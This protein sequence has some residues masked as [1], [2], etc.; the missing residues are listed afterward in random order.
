[1]CTKI[2]IFFSV[3]VIVF[4]NRYPSLI[5]FGFVSHFYHPTISQIFEAALLLVY[6]ILYHNFRE[7]YSDIHCVFNT[8]FS[9]I[10]SNNIKLEPIKTYVEDFIKHI[11]KLNLCHLLSSHSAFHSVGCVVIL[12]EYSFFVVICTIQFL[13]FSTKHFQLFPI[14]IC[15]GSS[16]IFFFL[17]RI[18][19]F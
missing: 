15:S 12:L 4:D 14:H 6:Q 8:S 16:V 3:V 7:C 5:L 18:P 13:D 19:I 17:S 1:M 9:T 11:Q 10:T 2:A